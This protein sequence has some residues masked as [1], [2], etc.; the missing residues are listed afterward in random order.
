ML[1]GIQLSSRRVEDRSAA[2]RAISSIPTGII[3]YLVAFTTT[4]FDNG[5]E[6]KFRF[7][8]GRKLS[9]CF[10]GG[11]IYRRTRSRYRVT[12]HIYPPD[13]YK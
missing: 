4:P 9:P 3:D 11:A 10:T 7:P 5:I 8:T 2:M 1:R 13:L 6:R 12:K